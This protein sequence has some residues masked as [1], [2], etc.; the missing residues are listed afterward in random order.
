[1]NVCTGH[2]CWC[3][4][5]C[6]SLLPKGTIAPQYLLPAT[7]MF[8]HLSVIKE[9]KSTFLVTACSS[10]SLDLHL[11]KLLVSARVREGFKPAPSALLNPS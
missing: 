4:A 8:E 5:M 9:G 10:A 7:G 3:D 2:T 6:G 1:M 11:T